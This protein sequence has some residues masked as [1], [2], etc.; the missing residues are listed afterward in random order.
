MKIFHLPIARTPSKQLITF[1]DV[2]CSHENI[3]FPLD[4]A[5]NA[6]NVVCLVSAAEIDFN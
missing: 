4:E 6:V 1:G 3:F 5:E 2:L